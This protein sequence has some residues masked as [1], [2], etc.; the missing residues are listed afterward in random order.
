MKL[1]TEQETKTLDEIIQ[2]AYNSSEYL[3]KEQQLQFIKDNYGILTFIFSKG[4][5]LGEANL[6]NDRGEEK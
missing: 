6:L 5:E 2:K 4:I 3:G 1:L